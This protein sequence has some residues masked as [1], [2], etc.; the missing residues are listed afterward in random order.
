MKCIECLET[1]ENK[2]YKSNKTRCKICYS[3]MVNARYH[4]LDAAGKIEYM[5]KQKCWRND[6]I[7]KVRYNAAKHRAKRKGIAFNI[8][9]KE[10]ETIFKKQKGKCF[11]SGLDMTLIEDDRY[12]LSIDRVDSSIGYILSNVVLVCSVVNSMKNDLSFTDFSVIIDIIH[13]N[14]PKIKF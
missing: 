3:K 7:F 10:L 1:D 2:F 9:I 5:E 6:N 12:V 4:N 11:Y 13:N 8:T 14:I